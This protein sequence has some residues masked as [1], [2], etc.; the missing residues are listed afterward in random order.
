MFDSLTDF[1]TCPAWDCGIDCC[2]LTEDGNGGRVQVF[3]L[4]TAA[5]CSDVEDPA[6]HED[7][8]LGN[9]KTKWCR[10]LD[11][12]AGYSIIRSAHI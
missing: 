12:L 4:L 5:R 9:F 11:S 6:I 7:F 8:A 1:H 2:I 10:Y 3:S